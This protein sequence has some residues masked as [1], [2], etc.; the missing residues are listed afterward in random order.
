M[1]LLNAIR[2]FIKV[3]EAGSIAA[4]ARNIGLSPA[5]VS[6]N[7]AR[8]EG[9]LQ[10]RLLSRTTR[11]MA[12]TPSGAQYY[13][14]VKHIERD[15]VLAE[16][17]VTTPDSEPQGR[18]CI[19]STS[20]FGRHVLAPLIPAF[21]ARYPLLSIELVTIDRRVNHAREDVDVSLRIAPQL[22]DQLLARRIARIPFICC[23]SPGYLQSAGVPGTPE[24]LRGHRCLVF[25]YPVDGRFLRWG[26]IRDG[27]R[28]EAEFGNVLISDD[29]DALTQMALHDGGITRLAEFIVRPHLASG[30]LVPLF[31]YC[32]SS[33]A[34]AQTEPMDIYLCLADRFAMT[35]KVRV[36]MD[37]LRECLGDSWQLQA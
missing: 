14:R 13:E 4:G 35:T 36:F 25:R 19:A 22:E 7:L 6:Q 20:A 37:Y 1:D 15:L 28:F 32:D 17:A 16:Q 2:C 21:S 11:S 33:Q 30:A 12:M 34:Y 27:L 9:H 23:A 26:F 10:V 29:I 5:A 3:V 31:E 18:L 8:L 24:A